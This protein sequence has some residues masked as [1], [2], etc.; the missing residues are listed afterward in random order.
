MTVWQA[1]PA[2]PELRCFIAE[3]RGW[4]MR[5][6]WVGSGGVEYDFLVYNNDDMLVFQREIDAAALADETQAERQTWLSAVNDDDCPRW[7]EDL[8]EAKDLVYG[9]D[10]NIQAQGEAFTAWVIAPDHS[11]S[12]PTQALALVRAWLLVTEKQP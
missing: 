7:D 12:G 6:I 10:H 4:H 5:K 11:A 2:G 9:M 3:R 1:L 8:D